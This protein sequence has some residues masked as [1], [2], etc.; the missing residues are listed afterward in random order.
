YIYDSG[1]D[2]Y[3][4]KS[5]TGGQETRLIIKDGGNVGIGTT[6][7]SGKLQITST[8]TGDISFDDNRVALYNTGSSNAEVGLSIA[9][10]QTGSKEWRI[11]LND[12]SAN[13]AFS[14]DEKTNSFQNTNTYM[15]ITSTGNVGIG[16]TGPSEKLDVEGNLQMNNNQILGATILDPGA[17]MTTSNILGS[18]NNTLIRA[19]QKYTVT[20]DKALRGGSIANMFDGAGGSSAN[21]D[22]V[23]L[24]VVCT[25]DFGTVKHYWIG[26][27]LHFTHNR[28]VTG[29]KI[30]KFAD[31]SSPY[32]CSDASWSTIYETTSNAQKTIF[33]TSG[34]GSGI[35][36]FRITLSGTSN[37]T[38][39][40]RIGEIAG[41]QWYCGQEGAFVRVTGDTIYGNLY[42]MNGNVGIGTTSPGAKLDVAGSLFLSTSG[43]DNIGGSGSNGVND[44]YFDGG[45]NSASALYLP[46][47]GSNDSLFVEDLD[48][49]GIIMYWADS[50]NVGIG[51][52]GPSYKLHV[53]GDIAYTGNIYD[54]SDIR[55]KEDIKPIENALSKILTLNAFSFIEKDS[56]SKRRNL[57]LSA[58][59][60]QKV[61]PEAVSIMNQEEGYLALS[62]NQLIPP[63]VEAIKDTTT[64][65][66]QNSTSLIRFGC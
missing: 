59:E 14:Y 11:G 8:A 50:G 17:F 66:H 9:A 12:T 22:D 65:R 20:C 51:T 56:D 63:I 31:T 34:L 28:W 60:V 16:T 62:Y 64:N 38:D 44:I 15:V 42:V 29:V 53:I 19:D 18:I 54:V 6:S 39:D 23:D 35:C 2:L 55:L 48:E 10:Y 47:E 1:G 43:D 37:Y 5:A 41:W 26:F 30:E 58:Q 40:I 24:P 32:S 46:N 45:S 7:P 27:A 57:G 52:T 33:I 4:D 13:L 25:I 49:T 3:F 36:K 61:F 21:W